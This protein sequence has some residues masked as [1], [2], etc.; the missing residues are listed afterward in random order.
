MILLPYLGVFV[1][2]I[3]QHDGMTERAIARQE[4]AQDQMAQ[5]VRSVSCPNEP[6]EQIAKGK[7]LL[8]EGAISASEFEQI[9]H[10]ALAA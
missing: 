4:A 10:N 1:Y 3:A 6:A 2:L 9:K 7:T 8:D 5:Y